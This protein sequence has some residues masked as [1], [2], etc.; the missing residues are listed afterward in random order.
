MSD[1]A[2]PESPAAKPRRRR[3]WRV[4]ALVL[5][6]MGV[7][8]LGYLVTLLP[9][10]QKAP[11]MANGQDG[12]KAVPL[13]ELGLDPARAEVAETEATVSDEQARKHLAEVRKLLKAGKY[14][15]ALERLNAVR[16]EVQHLPESLVL[17]GN[18]LLGKK[19]YRTAGDFFYA[20]V[21]RDPTLADGYFGFAVAA[22]AVGDLPLA[23]GGMRNFLHMQTDPD[24]YR[25]KVAQARSAIWEWESRLGRGEWGPTKGIP[26]GFTAAELK[27]DGKGVGT[28]MPL[29]GTEDAQ[30]V[31]RYE[32]KLS[33]RIK[34]FD[35]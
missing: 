35:K 1:P 29:M 13:A 19:D 11:M 33:D 28:K 17:V 25:L 14:D 12:R 34:M 15:Q 31:S 32:I 5:V 6:V 3:D 21:D 9:S 27:R 2:F 24:K 8:V 16:P 22:E 20:A 23:I 7:A 26:P 4:P 10:Q 30:G 18:A